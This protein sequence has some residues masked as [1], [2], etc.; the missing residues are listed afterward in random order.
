MNLIVKGL[1][2]LAR[3]HTPR[4]IE[5]RNS[6]D[7]YL[8]R[9]YLS[10]HGPATEGMDRRDPKAPKWGLYLH[11]FHRSDDEQELHNHPWEWAVSFILSAGYSE[12]RLVDGQV[13]RREVRPGSLNVLKANTFH[14]VDLTHGDA[15]TLFLVGP[16]TQS[17]GF[18]DRY[19]KQFTNWKEF[20]FQ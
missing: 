13:I 5:G 10:R 17:W 19:T 9:Y 3:N 1:L 8:T 6:D 4:V 2:W 12:E 16:I 14:R 20:L 18:L 15:W 11:H 7:P